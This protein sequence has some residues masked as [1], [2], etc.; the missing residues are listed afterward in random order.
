MA[1]SN[2]N[3]IR[4]VESLQNIAGLTP[5]KER[6]ERKQQEEQKQK[7]RQE[8]QDQEQTPK[9]TSE[10]KPDNATREQQ[11]DTDSIDYCA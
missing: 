7:K 4:P 5:V 2:Y 3:M 1:D 9:D 8:Q 10:M 6:K 11:K